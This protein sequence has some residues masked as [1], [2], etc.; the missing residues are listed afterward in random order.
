VGREKLKPGFL[1][2]K[3]C[4]VSESIFSTYRTGENRV[5]ASILAVLR[6]LA[7]PRIERI[8][9]ALMEDADFQLVRF[10]NQPAKGGEGVPDGE[11]GSSFRL[12]LETKIVRNALK[13]ERAK[14][15][16]HLD[17][18]NSTH[19]KARILMVL[20]P[21]DVQP[22]LIAEIKD[23]RLVWSSFAALNQAIDELL[24]GEENEREVISER[25]EFLLRELQK[26]LIA[27]GL[28]GSSKEV[29]VIPARQAW[30]FYKQHHVYSCPSGR[31]FQPVKYLAFYTGNEI[32]PLV[33]KILEEPP[34][35]VIVERGKYQGRLG[36]VVN[37]M[38]DR[39]EKGTLPPGW[40]LR[41]GRQLKVFL[42]S[43]PDAPETIKLAE[44]I[45]NDLTSNNGQRIAFTQNR[46][47][48]S[49]DALRK[50]KKTS[51]LGQE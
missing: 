22:S 41:P 48:V 50:A 44:A 12:L 6:C 7:L 30:D 39:Y 18:L 42:L 20:T 2:S 3:E 33:P 28:I 23:E 37:E 24:S 46:R 21:D 34:D 26:M 4:A 36:E 16:R 35:P 32:R 49:L 31:A 11:I 38:L 40:D 19:E 45:I 10:E 17:R 1:D 13:R 29:L 25:E 8:L 9:G 43:A 27:E 51:E 5:T 15:E 47:Y 14:L